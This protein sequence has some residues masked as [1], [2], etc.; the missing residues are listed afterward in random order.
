MSQ[1]PDARRTAHFSDL[2]RH[3]VRNKIIAPVALFLLLRLEG[4][5]FKAL[6]LSPQNW[7]K[8][9]A[10]GLVFGLAMFIAFN[11][12][13]SSLMNWFLPRSTASGPSIFIHLRSRGIYWPGCQSES[14]V[15]V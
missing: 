13:L 14:S 10:I 1:N 11:V 8:H 15:G 12:V 9:L 4:E 2:V 7:P 6:G 5:G 3:I